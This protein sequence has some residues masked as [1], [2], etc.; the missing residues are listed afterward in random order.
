MKKSILD[1]QKYI[2]ASGFDEISFI[3]IYMSILIA[4]VIILVPIGI[5]IESLI[6]TLYPMVLAF[7][8]LLVMMVYG[9]CVMLNYS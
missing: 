5:I 1:I 9:M 2:A 6:L 7:V 8:S 3:K 4:S